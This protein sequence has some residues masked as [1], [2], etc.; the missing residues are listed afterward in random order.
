MRRVCLDW[1]LTDLDWR[2]FQRTAGILAIEFER[3]GIARMAFPI[4]SSARSSEPVLHSNHHLGTTR[5]ASSKD[6]GVVNEHCQ[7]H[8][9]NNLYIIGGGVFPTVSWANPTF[10]L[11]AL[12]FRLVDHLFERLGRSSS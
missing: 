12:T 2:T 9:L 8:D 6:D 11:I 4:D 7:T 5:M 3:L 10:T 1:Q